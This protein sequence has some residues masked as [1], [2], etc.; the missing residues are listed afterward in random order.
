M[1]D[2]IPEDRKKDRPGAEADGSQSGGQGEEEKLITR[3][4]K[5]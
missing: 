2:H 5:D 4:E 1:L 3:S